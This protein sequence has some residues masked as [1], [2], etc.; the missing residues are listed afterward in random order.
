LWLGVQIERGMGNAAG[1]RDYSQRLKSE[2]PRSEE[3]KALLESE[4][5]AG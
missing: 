2:Y 5:N 3:T 1:V 4:R